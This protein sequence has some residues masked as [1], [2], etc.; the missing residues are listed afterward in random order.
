MGLGALEA[1][2]CDLGSWTREI[3]ERLESDSTEILV[4]ALA[5]AMLIHLRLQG[6]ARHVCHLSN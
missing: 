1:R 4:I 2:R 3:N 5:L 6:G